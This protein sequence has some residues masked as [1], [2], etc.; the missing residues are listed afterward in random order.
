MRTTCIL[1]FFG[2]ALS[3][4]AQQVEFDL[5]PLPVLERLVKPS[6]FHDGSFEIRTGDKVYSFDAYGN[7]RIDIAVHWDSVASAAN[8]SLIDYRQDIRYTFQPVFKRKNA[9]FVDD[10]GKHFS[11]NN[12][13]YIE[14][15][16]GKG[17]F[18]S[19]IHFSFPDSLERP[20]KDYQDSRFAYFEE[21][22][23]PVFV[24]ATWWIEN[25]YYR[26]LLYK[27]RLRLFDNKV[28]V[29][30]YLKDR[31]PALQKNRKNYAWVRVVGRCN[32]QLIIA[33]GT[34]NNRKKRDTQYRAVANIEFWSLSDDGQERRIHRMEVVPRRG[35]GCFY[36]AGVAINQQPSSQIVQFQFGYMETAGT[37]RQGDVEL[38]IGIPCWQIA[39]FENGE[40]VREYNI[41]APKTLFFFNPDVT[42]PVQTYV[43]G[44]E[45]VFYFFDDTGA[46]R[47]A[48]I[49]RFAEDGAQQ[50]TFI[51]DVPVT[52]TPTEGMEILFDPALGTAYT[53]PFLEP[54]ITDEQRSRCGDCYDE[55]RATSRIDDQG[56]VRILVLEYL[57]ATATGSGFM[58]LF[59]SMRVRYTTI[60]P[61]QQ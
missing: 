37:Y 6:I 17:Q 4:F 41:D 7:R 24:R 60:P 15:L 12:S 20:G 33:T 51:P 48:W 59:H 31:I 40:C 32:D 44:K 11:H 25:R 3:V 39:E 47:M 14:K 29:T 52:N 38:P 61:P 55:K 9:I 53:D 10:Y 50:T 27:Y 54:L 1:T 45:R 21:N 30:A 16:D 19:Y 18:D 58:P 36:A 26:M 49:F 46:D 34:Q 2:C 23:D 42:P 28:E 35:A 13:I 8:L 5:E 43:R 57:A 22:G 56:N